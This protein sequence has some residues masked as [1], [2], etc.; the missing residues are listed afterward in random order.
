MI[1]TR[2]LLLNSIIV[3]INE[4]SLDKLGASNSNLDIQEVIIL[5]EKVNHGKSYRH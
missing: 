4:A 5:N 3:V 2:P 1:Y